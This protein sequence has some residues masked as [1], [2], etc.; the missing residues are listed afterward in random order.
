MAIPAGCG[1]TARRRAGVMTTDGQATPPEGAAFTAISS[2]AQHTCG[3]REDG[4]AACWGDDDWG[5]ATPPEGGAFT[6]ISSGSG[7]I[8]AGCGKTAQR[9]A[10][11]MTSYDQTTPPEGAAFTAISSGA[12]R[13][14]RFA[15]RRRGGLLG[16][17]SQIVI[18]P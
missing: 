17:T 15:G 9:H 2:G 18:H 14:C 13:T 8:P 3:L 6:A 5:Q 1:K 11:A 12:Q 7:C 16:Q 4:S 10:G